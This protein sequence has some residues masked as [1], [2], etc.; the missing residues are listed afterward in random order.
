MHK[1]REIECKFDLAVFEPKN[2]FD[3]FDIYIYIRK[4]G[5]RRAVTNPTFMPIRS[6]YVY[7]YTCRDI[8]QSIRFNERSNQFLRKRS[9]LSVG[10]R[11]RFSTETALGQGIWNASLG[12][13]VRRFCMQNV[14]SRDSLHRI[15]IGYRATIS[16]DF[17]SLQTYRLLHSSYSL[18]TFPHDAI[19]FLSR[20]FRP[21]LIRT[22]TY[23]KRYTLFKS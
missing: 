21:F 22:L 12:Y 11:Y 4:Y 1:I 6:I 19:F 3:T 18:F 20:I 2:I 17:Y 15:T 10:G 16:R 14:F 8:I 23:N 13:L 7:M 9:L 5:A